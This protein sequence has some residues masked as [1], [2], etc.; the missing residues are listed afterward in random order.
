MEQDSRDAVCPGND[1]S[2]VVVVNLDFGNGDTDNGPADKG[3][4][5]AD[6]NR[7]EVSSSD[8]PRPRCNLLKHEPTSRF[9]AVHLTALV[10][11]N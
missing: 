2:D 7:G 3:Y 10:L 11:L 5:G 1:A 6:I 9:P 8:H 4:S